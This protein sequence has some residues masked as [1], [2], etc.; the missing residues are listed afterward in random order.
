MRQVRVDG[1]GPLP[2]HPGMQM[3]RILLADGHRSFVE[4]LA[5]RL[6]EEPGLQVVGVVV[7]PEEA[8]RVVTTQPVDVAVL[9]VDNTPHGYVGIGSRLQAIRPG[10]KLVGVA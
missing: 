3:T 6:N 10:L 4:A 5:M 1:T 7:Q 8:V 2:E 9:A